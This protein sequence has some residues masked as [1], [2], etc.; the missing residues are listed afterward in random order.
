MKPGHLFTIQ[1]VADTCW[2][3]SYLTDGPNE[4]I[5]TIIDTG[6]IP[7]LVGLLRHRNVS[8]VTPSLR[9]IGEIIFIGLNTIT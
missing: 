5:A 1:V 3:L 6:V 8:I 2:A 7:H 4:K 9:A